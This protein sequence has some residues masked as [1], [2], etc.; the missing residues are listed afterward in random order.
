MENQ[1]KDP[2]PRP[3]GLVPGLLRDMRSGLTFVRSCAFRRRGGAWLRG[4]LRSGRVMLFF[5][6]LRSVKKSTGLSA[7][8]EQEPRPS[9]P[10]LADPVTPLAASP[11]DNR[12]LSDAA[13]A[14]PR[15]RPPL[16]GS[17][18]RSALHNAGTMQT[19]PPPSPTPPR[20]TRG[21]PSQSCVVPSKFRVHQTL[22]RGI[23]SRYS[24]FKEKVGIGF[25]HSNLAFEEQ[26]NVKPG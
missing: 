17:P 3:G 25:L 21:R 4:E 12:R 26:W 13:L 23:P 2:T 1:Q 9:R 10:S 5:T 16:G 14:T 7:P 20:C 11:S 24:K 8:L 18:P 19:P 6:P 15:P 22:S